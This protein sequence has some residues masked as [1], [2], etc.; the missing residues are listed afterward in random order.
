MK[1]SLEVLNNEEIIKIHNASTQAL[2]TLGMRFDSEQILNGL[3]KIGAKVDRGSKTAVIPEKIVENAIE[4]NKRLIKNG[5]K[6]HLLNGV[7]SS[8]SKEN[9]I[10]AKISGAC[11]KY[12]DWETQR[13]KEA[14]SR[15]L[16][17]YIRIGEK[18][19][20]VNF[21]GN[22]IVMNSDFDGN[23]I[24]E[25]M[26][27]IETAALIAKNTRKI[28]SVT[29][30]NIDEIDYL[31][32]I[33]IIARGS[34]ENYYSNPCL[35]SAK[36]TISPFYLDENSGNILLE[37]AKRD[38]PCTI[39]PMPITGV[40][41]PVTKLGNA[42]IGN[43]EILGVLTAIQSI[44]PEAAVGGGTISGIMD[45]QTSV[46]S[47]SA[48]EAILQDIAVAEVHQRLY[49]FDYLIGSGYTDAKYPNAQVLSEKT[50]KF[51]FTYLS[52]R[53]T[54]P[55]GL[56]DSGAIFCAEQALVDI[57]I[58]RYIHSHFG[59]FG[60]FNTIQELI[61][62]IT[63]V[64]IRGHYISEDHTL[65]HFKEN[66]MPQIF[67]MSSFSTIEENKGK[68]IYNRAHIRIQEILSSTDFY[69]LDRDRSKEIDKVV[70]KAK[71]SIL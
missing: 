33:G 31:V 9:K 58:C 38:L 64:G 10:E 7:T 17:N 24:H 18:I 27:R 30:W 3:N 8:L 39:L 12:L 23:N 61:D 16:L 34:K 67:D 44:Y 53:Y 32:E 40:S 49:G 47:F 28:G 65:M 66:W 45:M 48:A 25:K 4:N 50:M 60:D 42:I 1:L 55:V 56:I 11:D 51:L 57:E 41:A 19:P 26:K 70:S 62:V 68:D 69:E 46:V 54:Y 37:F 6:L 13:V 59:G 22:A 43:A 15:E 29:V 35:I 36:E 20:E 52:G 5:K 21:V 63:S 71:K 14:N 2:S